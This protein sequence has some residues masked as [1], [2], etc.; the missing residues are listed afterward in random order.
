MDLPTSDAS[1]ELRDLLVNGF[2]EKGTACRHMSE[3]Q[4]MV[5]KLTRFLGQVTWPL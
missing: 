5:P 2:M 4:I 3:V 1:M